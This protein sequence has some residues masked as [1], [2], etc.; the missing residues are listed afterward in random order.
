[1]MTVDHSAP[2]IRAATRPTLRTILAARQSEVY[3][4]ST[5]C[6]ESGWLIRAAATEERPTAGHLA[7]AA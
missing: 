4:R 3:V 7:A 2:R 1:M 5:A 6:P